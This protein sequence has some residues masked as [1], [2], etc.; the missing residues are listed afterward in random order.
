MNM[1]KRSELL[2]KVTKLTEALED[3]IQRL[4]TI[5]G[6]TCSG[7][8]EKVYMAAYSGQQRAA[9]ANAKKANPQEEPL[10]ATMADMVAENHRLKAK[11]SFGLAGAA[12]IG[13]MMVQ[14]EDAIKEA[15]TESA[16]YKT[17]LIKL[18]KEAIGTSLTIAALQNQN[19][20][21]A[22]QAKPLDL[23]QSQGGISE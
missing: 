10:E 9:L 16:M 6:L 2:A 14:L 17:A 22:A 12:E 5:A 21:L 23:E 19:E 11:I 13:T 4:D 3:A 20:K 8:D 18:R 1:A 15:A 7:G